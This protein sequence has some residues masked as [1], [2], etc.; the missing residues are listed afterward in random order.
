[1]DLCSCKEEQSPA[2]ARVLVHCLVLRFTLLGCTALLRFSIH[3]SLS[4]EDR[5]EKHLLPKEVVTYGG[6]REGGRGGQSSHLAAAI[7]VMKAAFSTKRPSVLEQLALN[8]PTV[9][10][11]NVARPTHSTSTASD[12]DKFCKTSPLSGLLSQLMLSN[13][14][15]L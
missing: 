3:L 12:L 10:D 2:S 8:S 11:R 1:M 6:G 14:C 9:A 5:Q 7:L 4:A 13:H 15:R